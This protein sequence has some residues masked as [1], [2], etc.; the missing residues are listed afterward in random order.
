M[1]VR[2]WPALAAVVVAL[3]SFACGPRP[4]GVDHT[5]DGIGSGI[6]SLGTDDNTFATSDDG[7][8]RLDLEQF[9]SPLGGDCPDG[10]N[11]GGLAGETLHHIWISNSPEGTVSKINTETGIEE[12][13]YLAGP[14]DADPSRTSVNLLGDAVVVDRAGGIAKIA[15]IEERCVDLDDDG[16]IDTS[17]GPNDVLAWGSDECV[18]W[19]VPLP[20]GGS[21]PNQFGP[22]PVAW[23]GIGLPGDC[24]KPRVW[25][26]WRDATTGFFR[27]LDGETGAELDAVSV[28]WPGNKW[29]PYGGATNKQGDFWV[30]GW[31]YGPL[32]RI[33]SD[34]LTTDVHE[35][36]EP[37]TGEQWTYGMALDADGHPWIAGANTVYH[38]DPSTED[39]D[40]I[41]V[42]GAS[43]RGMMIDAD[44]RGWLANNGSSLL[45]EID[46]ITRTV[47]H[48]AIPLPGAVVPVGISIDSEG[49]VWV[50]D[51]G[52]STAFKVDPDTYQTLLTVTG[53]NSP[54]TYSDMT[55][56]ALGLVS[57][58]PTG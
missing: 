51:E 36:P 49:A 34:D 25:V 15:V 58:P 26:G 53:L 54:Y 13:R 33:D 17:K 1:D 40:F 11:I 9:D 32:V 44:G 27:R 6:S 8:I 38:F 2:N 43:F 20:S 18:L 56:A 39:W 21:V 23:E 42:P 5:D 24:T 22:R 29:G 28:P 55:G 41:D 16:E 35:I 4:T 12:A 52:T 31:Q 50:V 37:P 48:P 46:T 7:S 30:L 10:T 3:G 45:V 19:H 57:F 14:D 47:A